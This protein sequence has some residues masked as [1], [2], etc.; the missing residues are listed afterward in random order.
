MDWRY[1]GKQVSH[2]VLEH[3]RYRALELRK[4][5]KRTRDIAEAFGVHPNSVS[6]W[7]VTA[8][9]DGKK[10]LR[11]KKAEGPLLKLSVKEMTKVLNELKQPATDFGF[12]TPLWTC[13]RVR[14]LIQKL[15]KKNLDNSNVW[16]LLRR[17]G[18]TNQKGKRRALEQNPKET[19]KWLKEEWPKIRAHAKR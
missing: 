17:M 19:K 7:F 12:D 5:G 6:R 18:L 16:R 14:Y 3:Y 4:M 8:D 11:S 1:E 9:K 15:M 2:E 13:K 10:A